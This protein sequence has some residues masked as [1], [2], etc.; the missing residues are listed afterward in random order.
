MGQTR[1]CASQVTFVH[2]FNLMVS[3]LLFL[4]TFN[5]VIHQLWLHSRWL[6]LKWST[7]GLGFNGAKTKC[8]IAHILGVLLMISYCS[9]LDFHFSDIIVVCAVSIYLS[10]LQSLFS[11]QLYSLCEYVHPSINL[12]PTPCSNSTF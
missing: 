12:T 5:T 7:I 3:V 4:P 10:Y 11:F 1:Y 8:R 6:L 2:Y 9:L